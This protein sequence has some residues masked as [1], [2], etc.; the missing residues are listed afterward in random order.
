M[1]I[2]PVSFASFSS[3]MRSESAF[4]SEVLPAPDAPITYRV[5]PG[6]A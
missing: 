1:K 4:I 2:S 3:D 6:N 5:Y